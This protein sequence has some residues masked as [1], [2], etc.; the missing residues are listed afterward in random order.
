MIRANPVRFLIGMGSFVV[1][2]VENQLV[3][4]DEY[5]WEC[6][7]AYMSA[8]WYRAALVVFEAI[9]LLY[10]LRSARTRIEGLCLLTFFGCLISSAFTFWDADAYR[11]FASTNALQALLVGLGVWA[12]YRAFGIH[13]TGSQNFSSSTKAVILKPIPTFD[14]PPLREPWQEAA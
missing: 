7:S 4:V 5:A 11:T 1:R 6:C 12:V 13:P 2:F 9:G 8:Q 14:E 3:Y 10:A